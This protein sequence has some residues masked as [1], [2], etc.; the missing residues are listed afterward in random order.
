VNE[1][2]HFQ[3][4][5]IAGAGF[6]GAVIAERTAS[7]FGL[8][9][10][11]IDRRTHIGGNS[12]S[13]IDG[14]T[15]VEFHKYGSHIF[16]TSDN[17]VWEY[18][19][20]FTGFNSYRHHVWTI[21]GGRVYPMPI[22]LS[23]INSF[24]GLALSPDEARALTMRESARDGINEP[25]NFE[26]KAVSLVGRPLYEAFISGYTAKQWEKDPKELAADIIT[27]LPVRYSYNTRYFSD[28]WEG[29]PLEG[30]GGLFRKLL[31]HPRIE[32]RLGVD[33]ADLRDTLPDALIVFTGA[34]DEY[35]CYRL[36]RL[37]WRTMNFEAERPDCADFQGTA[38]VNYADPDIPYT[39]IHEFKHYHPERPDTGN[40]LIFREYSRWAGMSDEPYYPVDTEANRR[41]YADYAA[42]AE[43][44]APEVVFCGRLGQYKYLD[45][46]DA[47]RE[48][49]RC[50]ADEVRPR[51]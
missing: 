47:V 50:Y 10:V 33:F 4:V 32:V 18:I 49:L 29:I 42:L 6:S 14:E 26:E 16:H 12:W 15:G 11:V 25:S 7:D 37:E 48:A 28:T 19:S 44:E 27:R 21:S 2:R 43:R 8:P 22:N 13:E 46:D 24:Y 39:R 45:M 38:V 17:E 1:L 3:K 35:F 40:T 41:L 30:Y 34:I 31:D 23:T 5:C 51:L 9:V 20:R 36:G